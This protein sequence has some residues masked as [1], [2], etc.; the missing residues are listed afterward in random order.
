MNYRQ[1][2]I[3]IGIGSA[4]ASALARRA[5]REPAVS[6]GCRSGRAAPHDDAPFSLGRFLAERSDPA[7]YLKSL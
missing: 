5:R 4:I 7:E 3:W 6:P 2:A 1:E